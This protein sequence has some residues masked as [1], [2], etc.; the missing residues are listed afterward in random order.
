LIDK[1]DVRVGWE[2]PLSGEVSRIMR[3]TTGTKQNPFRPS[4][5]YT[6]VADLRPFDIPAVLHIGCR[7]GRASQSGNHKIELIDTGKD[8]YGGMLMTMERVFFADPRQHEIMRVDL[9][10]DVPGVSVDWFQHRARVKFKQ[11]GAEIGELH[12][13]QMG[14]REVQT[15]YFGK[16]P[17][18]Y[19]IY[20]KIAEW[21]VQ[22]RQL[23][24]GI[25][26]PPSFAD[27]Y[28][29]SPAEILTRVERQ[30]GGGR[31]PRFETVADL[32]H[33]SEFNP[34][35][36]LEFLGGGKQEPSC[37]D[38]PLADYAAGMFLRERRELWGAQHFRSWVYQREKR[39]SAR[40]LNRFSDF[41]PEDRNGDGITNEGLYEL[42]RDSVTKQLGS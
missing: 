9:A 28:G 6:A 12:Y 19:R 17:N 11:W 31:V 1:L 38:Y 39:N 10:A 30:C 22:Y 40:F 33:A 29:Q 18:C 25:D 21:Q 37:L 34:F 14:R 5:H 8:G 42:Y 7:H 24:R 41:L 13:S 36:K 32:R 20:D 16:R 15:L 35:E 4:Q 26:N 2:A 3:E 23:I 27:T